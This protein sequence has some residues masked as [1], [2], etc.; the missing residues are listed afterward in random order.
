MSRFFRSNLLNDSSSESESDEEDL[1][2]EEESDQE[3]QKSEDEEASDSEAESAA[4]EKK[5][6][7]GLNRFLKDGSDSSDSDD[8]DNEVRGKI[9]SAKDKL[10]DELEAIIKAIYN[11]RNVGSWAVVSTSELCWA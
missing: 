8:S 10:V 6:K 7:K 9:R 5:K 11:A 3:V 4:E 2:S 1:Y